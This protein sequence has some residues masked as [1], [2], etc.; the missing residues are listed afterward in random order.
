MSQFPR[1]LS[2]ALLLLNFQLAAFAQLERPEEDNMPARRRIEELIRRIEDE[3]TERPNEA[4]NMFDVAWELAARAEDPVIELRTGDQGELPTGAHQVNVG[5]RSQLF[6]L[7]RES[8]SRMK[9]AYQEI[10]SGPAE[11]ALKATASHPNEYVKAIQRY[12]FAR[13]AQEALRELINLRL[14]RGEYLSA[15]LQTGRLNSVVASSDPSEQFSQLTM[16]WN[17]GMPDEAR[18]QLR[19]LI[20]VSGGETVSVPQWLLGPVEVTLPDSV[21]DIESFL[22]ELTQSCQRMAIYSVGP[23][24]FQRLGS[25]RRTARQ[26]CGPTQV[27]PTWSTSVF[28]C[29]WDPDLEERLLE[30]Q[31]TILTPP[32]EFSSIESAINRRSAS[33]PLVVGDL[34]I[35]R[36][37][38]TV[39]AVNRKTGKL[40]WESS[41]VDATLEELVKQSRSTTRGTPGFPGLSGQLRHHL[42]RANTAGQLTCANGVVFAVEEV[43]ALTMFDTDRQISSPGP[44]NYLRAYDAQ[45]GQCLGMAGG[46]VGSNE[47]HPAP[48]PLA[49][50]YVLGA[51]LVMGDRIYLMAENSQGIFLL[52]LNLSQLNQRTPPFS[53]RPVHSQLLSVPRF[54]LGKHAVRRFS[55]VTPS[56]GGGL[57]ICNTCDEKIVAVSAEDHSVRWIYRYPSNVH[58]PEI[59]GSNRSVIADALRPG[60]SADLDMRS[61]WVD[62]LPRILSDRLIVTPRDA[63][64]LFCLELR[65]G[66]ELWSLPRGTFHQ[67]AWADEERIIIAGGH[68]L[69]CVSAQTGDTLWRSELAQGQVSGTSASDGRILQVPTTAG[70]IL[71]LDIVT[72]RILVQQSTGSHIPGNLISTG[73]ALYSQTLTDVHCLTGDSTTPA[74]PQLAQAT[75]H[76][77]DTE[78]AAAEQGLRQ[79]VQNPDVASQARPMLRDLLI[80][81]LR[82]DR[83]DVTKQAREIR[84]LILQD[85]PGPA[86][87]AAIT[88]SLFGVTP[89]GM[90]TVADAWDQANS[91]ADLLEKLTVLEAEASLRSADEQLAATRTLEFLREAIQQ[92]SVHADADLT[93]SGIARVCGMIVDSIRERD[94]E[95]AARYR[96]ALRLGLAQHLRATQ[97]PAERQ[98]WISVCL[99][100]DFSETALAALGDTPDSPDHLHQLTLQMAID[101]Q[102]DH[103]GLAQQLNKQLNTEELAALRRRSRRHQGFATIPNVPSRATLTGD[104]VEYQTS[105]PPGSPV[106]RGLWQGVP[107]AIELAARSQVTAGQT[108][109]PEYEYKVVGA[110]GRF[111]GWTFQKDAFDSRLRAVDAGGKPQWTFKSQV[112]VPL[113]HRVSGSSYMQSI[114]RYIVAM[115]PVLVVRFNLI[116]F[117]LDCTHASAEKPPTVLWHVDMLREFGALRGNRTTFDQFALTSYQ[118]IPGGVAP[119]GEITRHGV[120]VCANGRLIMLDLLTGIPRWSLSGI[121]RDV[122]MTSNSDTLLLIS[123]SAGSIQ[124]IRPEDGRLMKTVSLPTWWT[125]AAYNALISPLDYDTSEQTGGAEGI[126]RQLSATRGMCLLS[127][128]TAEATFL[129]LFNLQRNTTEWSLKFAAGTVISNLV[130]GHV[131][132]IDPQG[133]LRLINTL[134]GRQSP[135]ELVKPPVNCRHLVLRPCDT[136]WVIMTDNV[137]QRHDDEFPFMSSVQVNGAMYGIDRESGKLTWTQPLDHQWIRVLNPQ[138]NSFPPVYPLLV[139]LRRPG[140]QAEIHATIFD[141]RTGNKVYESDSL[142]RVLTQHSILADPVTQKLVIRFDRRD[143]EFQYEQ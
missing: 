19:E 24:L 10:A 28:G 81:S 135:T 98:A 64:R 13:P 117:A 122:R 82:L 55:G 90:V 120:P 87:V 27:S 104:F 110:A 41:F 108:R 20:R 52:Q 129:E 137:D 92:P 78:I 121:P 128:H 123:P 93:Q 66:K 100:F 70:T 29:V 84:Q 53:L 49:G 103:Q 130:D 5:S 60:A 125:D 50:F 56:F 97:V 42:V 1:Y 3:R 132:V 59:G 142:G 131:A 73:E 23:E 22:R 9:N 43:A 2:F 143:V 107:E 39:R 74:N 44:V 102:P 127:R 18:S 119:V 32:T 61:R 8:P 136:H 15:A 62:A 86:E 96:A 94:R 99:M 85:G 54:E 79:L 115:G 31:P 140:I 112:E 58:S 6:R 35:Y 25:Y 46:A 106:I 40:A 76:L 126:R 138:A 116:L 139:L 30:L 80:E 67:V 133:A 45:T 91:C 68:R 16:Y 89:G 34:L 36:G 47:S 101:K 12:L 21:Q 72:G 124:Q 114:D 83:R 4:A 11:L 63:D 14:S 37:L 17:A 51:P 118:K 111:E 113:S 75:R 26:L 105:A 71:T 95:S 88:E 109:G 77:L 69:M 141:M 57:L 33:V 38:V 7:Y 48:N 65:T 134:T